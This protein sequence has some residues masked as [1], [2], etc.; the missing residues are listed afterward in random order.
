MVFFGLD[1]LWFLSIFRFGALNV[2][3]GCFVDVICGIFGFGVFLVASFL[4]SFFLGHS[5]TMQ[6]P[7]IFFSVWIFG[8]WW[9]VFSYFVWMDLGFCKGVLKFFGF[10]WMD[11]G[12]CGRGLAYLVIFSSFFK[13][14]FVNA[15]QNH[16][17]TLF[18]VFVN[19]LD[20]FGGWAWVFVKGCFSS[21]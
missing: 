13:S 15:P 8:V 2:F 12:F 17:K 6:K 19:V 7:V 3:G 4:A 21:F 1:F 20:V 9:M 18:G 11:L 5:R 10:W 14:S 16:S